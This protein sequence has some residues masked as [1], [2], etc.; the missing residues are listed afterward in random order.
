MSNNLK[1]L[2]V[3]GC[4]TLIANS[5]SAVSDDAPVIRL[6]GVS[7]YPGIGLTERH[8]SNI[9]QA[10]DSGGSPRISSSVAVLSPALVVETE[11]AANKY[12]FTYSAD[13]GRYS[14]SSAD[15]YADHHYLGLA[16][17]G[18]SS[19][20]I[21]KLQPEYLIGHDDRGST[22]ETNLVPEPNKWHSTLLL[23][24][25]DYGA[26]EARGH[27]VVD[28]GYTAIK[29]QNNASVTDAYSRKLTSAAGTLYVRVLP[30]TSLLVN[31]KHTG[32]S[33]DDP[34]ST[35][36]GNE[37]MLR[38]GV[39]WEA[40]AQ[41]SGEIKVGKLQKNFDS[42]SATQYSGGSWEADMNWSPVPYVNVDLSTSK[43][44][45]ET[46]LLGSSAIMLSNT[47]A[48]LSYE[49]NDRITLRAN[50]YQLKQDF[51]GASRS[52]STNTFGLKAEYKIRKWLIGGAEYSNSVKSSNDANN[53][54]KR[55]IFTL[56]VR[57][58]L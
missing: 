47:G 6:G 56:S 26:E 29:Y 27:L 3:C 25:F 31:A 9:T 42:S 46:T 20:A 15:N 5:A 21:L 33:Y 14:S 57:T 45:T 40:T 23:G 54:F 58:A 16:E 38:A 39:K 36:S 19:S 4:L 43:E 41:T 18:L 1:N 44:A 53:D 7:A 52:D 49:L 48:N 32:I 51:V 55:N 50:G 2:F 22:F 12:S 11:Q 8:D 34:V 37:Q 17:F 30:K 35:L 28:M 13:I 10:T 24:T